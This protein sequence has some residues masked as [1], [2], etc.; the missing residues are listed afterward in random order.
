MTPLFFAAPLSGLC[1]PGSRTPLRHA[2]YRDSGA[3]GHWASNVPD[4]MALVAYDAR[5]DG[6]QVADGDL[7][8]AAKIDGFRAVV[9]FGSEEDG[10]GGVTHVEELAGGRAIAPEDHFRAAGRPASL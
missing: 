9:A 5:Y 2:W 10:L 8:A 1:G 4:D 7:D 6:C 3:A